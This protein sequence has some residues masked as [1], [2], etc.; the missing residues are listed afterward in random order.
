MVKRQS[1]S[2][3]QQEAKT[4]IK[5]WKSQGVSID[6]M[7]NRLESKG[8]PCAKHWIRSQLNK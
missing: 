7:H 3:L 2:D 4:W 8:L 5:K 1:D 6:E